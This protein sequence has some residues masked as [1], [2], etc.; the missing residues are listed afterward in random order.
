MTTKP[1]EQPTTK[2]RLFDPY[3]VLLHNDDHNGMDYVV[4]AILKA[5]PQTPRAEALT[6]MQ[7]AHHHGVA[8]V[9]AAP[10]EHAEMYCDRLRSYGLV[11]SI[12]K[13]V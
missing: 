4:E 8:I 9:I 12:E 6:I 10:L 11:S 2:Q 7:E 3:K 1:L 13:D 5:V